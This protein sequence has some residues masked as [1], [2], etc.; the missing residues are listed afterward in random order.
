[1]ALFQSS[2]LKKYLKQL[3]G[4]T[5]AKAYKKYT[6]YFHDTAI[7]Q[8]IRESKEEQYQAK[9]LDELFVNVLG[10]TLNPQPNFNLT[11]EFKNV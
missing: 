6:K 10:Y 4:D 9:L 7:Q 5:V 2:V 11:T 3:D 1:M 8:N